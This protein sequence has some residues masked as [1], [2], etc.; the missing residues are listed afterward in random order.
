M[1]NDGFHDL[2][3]LVAPIR[4]GDS[5][6]VDYHCDGGKDTIACN[7]PDV[8]TDETNLVIKAA[9]AFR[10]RHSFAG[11]FHFTLEKWIPPGSGLGGGSSNAVTAL[12]AMNRALDDALSEAE[13]LEISSGLG[14]DCPLFLEQLPIVMRGRGEV[15]ERISE[16]CHTVLHGR[17]ILLFRP[18]F[19]VSTV[20]AYKQMRAATDGKHYIPAL[21]ADGQLTEWLKQPTW[22]S[23]PL[24]NNLQNVVFEKYIALPVLLEQ[25]RKDF[26][27]PC[28]MSGSGSSC[29]A[30][31]RED[32]H[33]Q[34]MRDVIKNAWGD[35]ALIVE[36][37]LI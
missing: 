23:L 11:S 7:L 27:V 29:F 34:A 10:E 6:V 14:S 31:L 19:A 24:V 21:E 9:A 15:V 2:V 30:L 35:D 8:P 37:S 33:V 22:D 3:S 28:M 13:L 17:P 18:S 12:M 5:V 1:R 36:T 20:W 25:L 32:T 26:G 4:F 16:A